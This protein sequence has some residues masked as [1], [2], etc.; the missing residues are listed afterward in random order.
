MVRDVDVTDQQGRLIL[1]NI[2]ATLPDSSVTLIVGRNGAGKSTMLDAM[3]GLIRL[4]NGTILYDD[5]PLWQGNKLNDDVLRRIG[6]VFQYPEQ[7]LFAPTVE[8][9]MAYSLRYL[10]LPQVE[11]VKRAVTSLE[12]MRLPERLLKETPHLL[13]GGQKRRVALASTIAIQPKWLLLDEPTSGLDAEG[14]SALLEYIGQ[15]RSMGCSVVIATHDLETLLPLADHIIVM[16]A[17]HVAAEVTRDAM[18]SM[19]DRLERV[20]LT[21]PT[22]LK[23]ADMVRRSGLQLGDSCPN[24]RELADAIVQAHRLKTTRSHSALHLEPYATRQADSQPSTA[25]HEA[26]AHSTFSLSTEPAGKSVKSPI[27]LYLTRLDPRSKWLFYMM[28]SIS[29][30]IQGHWM[31]LAGGMAVSFLFILCAKVPLR[32][33]VKLSIPLLL[34]FVA[35]VVVSGIGSGG[36]FQLQ[37]ASSWRTLFELLKIWI[38]SMLGLALTMTTSQLMMKQAIERSL[39]FLQHLRLPVGAIAL[40]ASLL[41]RFIPV[42]AQEYRRF[43]KIVKARSK[44]R[45]HKEGIGFRQLPPMMIPLILSLF[46]LASDLTIAM[47]ARG[48]RDLRTPRTSSYQLKMT[49]ADWTVVAIGCLVFI[50]FLLIDAVLL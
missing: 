14:V 39:G 6:N 31:G 38:V 7:Q 4:S 43:S 13:S 21:V 32:P 20:G 12:R 16:Q 19:V 18:M 50:L 30:L 1:K 26:I 44:D 22:P 23:L 28:L 8:R 33:M 2:R 46:Q 47:Q 37:M 10:K 17:G 48:L 25:S 3:S 42:L 11:V 24:P 35:S 34:L 36:G 40:G 15:V 29:I 45:P 49:G 27:L 5:L 9:E 41:L